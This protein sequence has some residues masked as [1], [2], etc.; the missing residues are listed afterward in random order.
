MER[1]RDLMPFTRAAH[2]S[3]VIA[4]V[5]LIVWAVAGVALLFDRL[6]IGLKQW[7]PRE[8]R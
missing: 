5:G 8:A 3:V 4:L 2:P 7:V 1:S 6:A